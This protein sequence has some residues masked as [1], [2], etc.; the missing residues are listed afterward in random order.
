M[1]YIIYKITN[2]INNNTYIGQHKCIDIDDGYMGSGVLLQR[3]KIKYGIENFSK[4]ILAICYSKEICN[5]LEKQYILLYR[6]IGK[7]EYN[8]ASGGDG[9]NGDANKGKH[10]SEE[11][12]EKL[13]RANLGKKQSQETIE[14]RRKKLIGQKKNIF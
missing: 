8:M 11:C 6:S 12:K 5:I 3:A 13:R 10:K 7:A 9:G 1:T 2:N 4:E 14:K